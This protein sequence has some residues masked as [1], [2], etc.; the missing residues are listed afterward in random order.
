[1]ILR[2]GDTG[3]VVAALQRT[4]LNLNPTCL[5]RFGAD[6]SLG[7]ESLRAA[8][9]LLGSNADN[10]PNE[11][12]ESEQITLHRQVAQ[13]ASVPSR[14][15]LYLDARGV[16]DATQ[17]KGRRTWDK[18]DSIVLHQT[19]CV[20]GGEPRRWRSVPI[21]YGITREGHVLHL[22]DEETLLWHAHALNRFSVGIE[23]DGH[24]E[25]VLGDP[26]THWNPPSDPKREPLRPTRPQIE[27]TRELLRYLARVFAARGGRLKRI[28]AHRQ[29]TD[30]R[31]SD[32]GSE[33]WQEIALPLIA[34]LSL[35]DA[36]Q[37]VWGEGQPIPDAWSGK[38]EGIRY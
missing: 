11:I 26:K 24:F 29:G 21:H 9:A 30:S 18:I 12:S 16:A 31:R 38:Q 13:R 15:V 25:G 6:G 23:I 32:P 7:D 2:K 34:E 4:L 10:E 22:H 37:Q 1:M 35:D 36:G 14:P 3:P 17:A 28:L 27:S 33:V 5:P 19:A 20:L 8:H